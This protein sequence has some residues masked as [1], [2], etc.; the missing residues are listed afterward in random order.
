MSPSS[1][2]RSTSDQAFASKENKLRSSN[3]IHGDCDEGSHAIPL[4]VELERTTT[5]S[6]LCLVLRSSRF[7]LFTNRFVFE[8]EDCCSNSSLESLVILFQETTINKR[9]QSCEQPQSLPF[10]PIILVVLCLS[11]STFDLP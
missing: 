2:A 6:S 9:Y 3:S 11:F 4:E 1:I 8:E 5:T 10:T 7:F